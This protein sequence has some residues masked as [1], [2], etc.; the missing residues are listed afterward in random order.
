M[1]G[2]DDEAAVAALIGRPPSIPFEV[3]LR[4]ASGLPCVIELAPTDRS[5]APQSN[6]F[7]LVDRE[8]TRAV[9]RLESRGGV[10]RARDAV[11]EAALDLSHLSYR[12]A[13][14][15]G[16]GGARAGVK[17]LHAHLAFLLAGGFSPVG[18]WTLY[19]VLRQE[20]GLAANSL[21][22]WSA[23]SRPE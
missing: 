15:R 2:E 3:V 7:W 9:S 11:S 5:G 13:P 18:V 22:N 20:P 4:S 14:G 6:W 1:A 23:A 10:A 17:C 12:R 8:L 19:E 16:V 21:A